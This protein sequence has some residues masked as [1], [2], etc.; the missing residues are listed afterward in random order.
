MLSLVQLGGSSAAVNDPPDIVGQWS[1]PQPWPIVAVHMS[2]TSTGEVFM[3]DGFG[4]ALNSE[5]LWNPATGTFREV[6]YGRNLF[7]SG[8]V[9]LAD[10]RTLLVGGHI[11]AYEGLKDTTLYNA[12]TDTY[13]R[14]ADMAE[15]RW[16]PTATQLPDG[17]VLAF[18]GDRIVQNRPGALPPFSDA[19]VNSLPEIYNPQT[20]TWTSLP[21]GELTSPLYPQ[22]F[23]LSDGRIVNV[24]PDTTTRVLTPGTWTWSTVATSPFDGHSAVMYRPNK[25]MKSGTWADPDFQGSSAYDAH[26]RTAVL[27]M[28]AETPAWRET[29]PM[30]HGRSYHTLTLLPDGTVLAS[31]GE[32][33]SDGVDLTRSVLPAEIW[34]PDTETWT[35]VASLSDGRLYHSTALLLPDGR[36]LMAGGGAIG[37]GTNQLTGEIYSPPYLFKGPRPT[38]TTSPGS[39]SYGT[40]FSVTTPN[41]AQIAKVSLIRSPS[42]THAL[43][44]N[45]RFQFLDF[46]TSGDS[47]T[48]EAPANANLAPPGDYL[49]FLVDTNGVPSVGSFIRQNP[50]PASGDTTPPTVSITAPANGAAVAGTL[51]VTANASDNDAIAGVQFKLDGANLG[52]EDTLAPYSFSWDTTE[53]GNGAHTLTAVAR[54]LTGNIATAT[55]VP[56]TVSNSGPPPGLV[57]AYGFDAGA[58]AIAADQAGS[59]HTGTITN[60]T[61]AGATAG[62]YGNALSFNGSNASVSVPDANDLDF[63]NGMT[64]EA[65][66]RPAALGNAYS[67]VVLKEQPGYYTYGLYAAT[68]NGR[69]S[70]NAMVD[71][72]DRETRGPAAL[73]LGVWS[74]L[75]ATYDGSVLALYVNGVQVS[76]L[77]ASGSIVTSAGGLKV[78]GNAVWGE[79]FSGLVDEVR[80]YNRALTATEIQGDMARPITNPD[81]VAPSAPGVLSATGGL[82]SAQLSWGAASDDTG[83]VRYNV[84]RG[85]SAGFAPTS[86]N[87]IAQPTGTSYTDSVAA[88]TYFYRVTAEDAAGNVG[89]VSN[90]ASA[91]VGDTSAPSAPG[92][93]SAVGAV[94]KATL[95]WSAASDNVAVVRY[96]VHRSSSAG[97]IPSL[98]N[99]IAQ[100]TGTGYVDTTSPGSYFYKVTAEDAAGNIGPASNEAAATVSADTTPPS[101]PTGLAATVTGSTVNLSWNAASDDVGV[102]RYNLHRGSSAGFIPSLG[103]RIAQPTGLSYADSGLATGSYFYK[104]TAEDAAG[105]IGPA[106][107]EAAAAVADATPPSAPGTLTATPSG[108]SINLSWGA[109]S[110]N[111]AVSRYNLHR[112]SSSGFTPSL[113]NRIAQP[114]GLSHSDTN[115]APGNYFYKLT[116]EDAA[117]NIG[118]LSNTANATVADTSPPSTP[119]LNA[120]GGAGQ[121]TLTWA[122]ATDNVAVSHYN[123][124]RS[125]T[126]SFT[127]TSAN[128]IAQPTTTSHTDTGLSAGTYHYKLTAE[129]AAGNTSTPSNQAS[130]TVT[131]PPV[132]GLVAAY[133][134]DTGTGTTITDQS[135]T[136]NNGTL[137][138]TTWAGPTQGRYGNALT[139]NGTN[140]SATIPDHPTLDLT[141]GMTLEAWVRPTTLGNSYRTVL[142]KERVGGSAYSLYANGSGNDRAPIAEAYT[143]GY[144]DA[145][146]TAQLP[147]GVWSH[148]AATYD[149]SVLALYVNGVQVS[150]L[151]ASGSIVTSAGGLK[152]GG[153]AVWGE[154]FSGLV[155]EVRLYNR[156]LTA[157]EIQGDMARPITNPDAVAPSAPGVL[158]ATG[159]LSSAQLSWGAASDDTGVV[160]YNVHRGTSAG[161]APTSGNRI[162]QPTGTSYTDSVAAGTYFYRVTAEDAAGNVGPVSNE[163]SAT[164][165]DTSAPSAPGTLSAVGAVGKATLAWSAASDNVA[166]VR[167]NVHR[168]SSAGF[169]PSLGNRIAQPTGTGYVDTTSPG[170]YFY[171]VTAEDAAGNIGPASNEA[172]ATVSADTTP[173][174]APTGLAATVTGSTVNLSWNAASDDVGVGRYNLHRGSSAGFIPS[175]GNRIAQPTG[176]SYADSGLATGSYFYKLTAEDAAGNIGPASN[177]AAAAVADAT[178]PSAPGT[179]TATPSGS[180]INLSWGAASDNVAV[181]R[182]NL[183]RGSSSGFTPS[184]GNRIAQPTGL[185]HSDTNLAPGNYFYKLTAEDAAGNI[186]PLSNTANATVADTSPPSTPTL[187][188]NGGAGQATLTWAAATDNVAVSHYNLHRSTTSSFTPTS[189][190]RIA[191]PTTTSHT[192]TGLSAGTYHYKLTAEDAAGNTSTPSNQASAT[193]TTPPVTGLVAA[194]GLDTGTGTTITDQSGTGNNG[195]LTNTTWAG[196]TQGRYG[197][198]LTFNGTNASATIPDHPT[199]DL[200]TGMTL[201]AWVRPTTLGNSWRTAIMKEQAGSMAYGLYAHGGDSGQKVPLGEIV[202]GGFRTAAG[203][204]SLSINTWTH[205]ATTYDGTTLR[206]FING[207]Q[208]GQLP[209]TGA[210]VTSTGSLRIGGNNIWG[211]WFEGQIDEIRIYNRALTATELQADMNTS[212]SSPDTSAPSAPGTL[213]ATG[214]LGQIVLSWGAATDN[215]AVSRYNVHRGTSAG[216]TPTTGNR[217]AQPAGTSYTDTGVA[218][219]TYYY[220]VTAEDFAGNVGSPG[221]EASA[222]A[223]ADTTPPTVSVSSPSSGATVSATVS[224]NANASDNGAVAGVQFKLDGANLGAEDSTAPYSISW[225][226]FTAGNGAHT[227]TA[228]ARD[229]AGNTTTS[230]GVSVTVSNTGSVGLVGAW[231]FDEGSGSSAADQSGRGNTGALSNTAW[232]TN[233]KFNGALSFN[234][235]N[236]WVSVADSASLDLTTGLTLEAWVRPAVTGG[237]RTA[238]AKDQP[239]SLAYGLYANSSGSFPGTEVFIGSSRSLNGTTPLPVGTWSH[240]ASTYDGTILRL[241]VNGTQVSQLLVAGSI[242]TSSAPLHVGGNGVWGEWFNGSI[243]EVRVY[244]RALGAA[245]IQADMVRSITPDTV[246]P[247]ITAR[248]PAPGAAGVNAGSS[249]TVRFNEL[250]SAGSITTATFELKAAGNIVVPANV[251]YDAATSTATLT[252]QA[253]LGYGATYTVTVKGGSGG[254]KDLAGNPLAADSTWS[255]SVEASPPP[256][257]VVGSTGNPFGSY[258]GEILRNEGL[259]AFTTI[260]VTFVSPAL[261]AQFDVVVLGDTPL[262]PAQATALTGWVNGGGN[263]IAMRPDK[264]LASLLG[265][266]DAGTTLTNAYLQ[267]ATGTTPGSGIVGSTIQ[268]HGTADRYSLN[269]ATS[270]ATLY[271]TAS[272][273]TSNPA[274][275]LRSV[276]SNGGQAAAFTYDLARSV[277]YTRQGNPAWSGQERD[278][279]VGIRPDDL[280]Y[281]AR[282]GDVQPDWVDTNKIAIPQSDEQQ[283]LLLNLVTV[284]ERD[285]LPLPRFWY[286]PRGEKAVV[287]MSGDDHSPTQAPGGTASHFERYKDLSPAGCVVADWECVRSTS[288][289]YPNATL[290]NAQ[291]AGYVAEGFEVGVHPLVS[292]CPTTATS[293][294]ELD[295]FYATQL[296]AFQAKY[297]S[298]PTQVSSRTH[299]VYWPDWVSN[300][301]VELAHGI[302]MDANYYHFPG[303]CIGA[304]AGFLN[305]GGFPMRF[306]ELDGTPVDVYQQNTNLTDE[307]TTSFEATID[308]LLDNAIGPQGYYGAF[309]A[310]MHTDGA[311]PHAGAEAIVAAAQARDVPVIS[312]RQLLDWVD[313]RNGSTIRGLSWNSGTLTFVT[314]AAAGSNGL[315]TLLP[316]QGPSG[317]LTAITRAG[318]PVPYTVQT[319]K[320]IQYAMFATATATYQAAYS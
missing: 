71:G 301:N 230:A 38:I 274:V 244:N 111:V 70:G 212:I 222:V 37:G 191:Q 264:Q 207:V 198:A 166:V 89:P 233:G 24:G 251:S 188:A 3:L 180:S 282:A 26:G 6:P 131:T 248:T 107:N 100:P 50:A 288:F 168:S 290:T 247:T 17:R 52:S 95:A 263:L 187:N 270:I 75:A 161:F 105:N 243:D 272:A 314:T 153:N 144:R 215:V 226:T 96:N 137:T 252:P 145:V 114:T 256:I 157:T 79:W 77:L 208:A 194:Y 268:F 4:P 224:V 255:F 213:T 155:D 312:Y 245:E 53:T 227:L 216:F 317:T 262:T 214:G 63:T 279:V 189:A 307:S 64:L 154:W 209:H 196:P 116:A 104:L 80:L 178:P 156:A 277:V 165:G 61:W 72:V 260:D 229:G 16:Y 259:N 183:H 121:A 303:P 81:A 29:S 46:T 172:A 58:G 122:A 1:A 143:T 287:V 94:G 141:T 86:G 18:A 115:L 124:H 271:S 266:T 190:N 112:G 59:G 126:S 42:V 202:S 231:A 2:L 128:R 228:V 41:A 149:G 125:T 47:L 65:W 133:G 249:A 220:K 102:G 273:A 181:S 308:S 151:L 60:A 217:V 179:L 44:M 85:T 297:T 120:N 40:S 21:S 294:E 158:S 74:H 14:G 238:L 253:A 163:A 57:A 246:A 298:V 318:S 88:G 19:S 91:T 123:L 36:V 285:K 22:L 132:T 23:V 117:G 66:V 129:D 185:S 237:W 293:A 150:T 278:G 258:L 205:L 136:G 284:M 219:G 241:Y 12:Q 103:N 162:A 200:T 236:A 69:P 147:L 7:C 276:G 275:T 8:H 31:G 135:G 84:H 34:N 295:T 242:A 134:L 176:L 300:A 175:L 171:K 184:L 101:A 170:S 92:T 148:L 239:G 33:R 119:T 210:I 240:V 309:G 310:N 142:M 254:V 140:A 82:S 250:M 265:L 315:Q 108:S 280:F 76:T 221:N 110:D 164:V 195:T 106:S 235:T 257:L 48:V 306:A 223:S 320:G 218:A 174:S 186:G 130:A 292:S 159:G 39:M 204:T 62:R 281:G 296:A 267:V 56:V 109:A 286:L 49:L 20:N 160:R 234:G 28:N 54:D 35:T 11:N 319:I 87:R 9:Q 43:D 27:D 261:L 313:G 199:L 78:G 269:G 10:G 206:L 32:S 225:D 192:D 30:A 98:G 182:Y 173:P 197:N 193:V 283:R 177:E 5:R 45:Q 90:E 289:V 211:E 51:D 304:K 73:P 118:P 138:N 83:V 13:F 169:I 203:T 25:I 302:R 139:F 99:R 146:G 305:G 67:T 232:V 316:L 152:V 311:A 97:F 167:Y 127:P 68:D 291:A 15:P 55:D 93:L 201:E 299:C 113:G